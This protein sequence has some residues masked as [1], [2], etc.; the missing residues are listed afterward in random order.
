MLVLTLLWILSVTTPGNCSKC[1]N[2]LNEPS[3]LNNF[4]IELDYLL[5]GIVTI[6]GVLNLEHAPE[7]GVPHK[8]LLKFIGEDDPNDAPI[9]EIETQV[10]RRHQ[11]MYVR[12][13]LNVIDTGSNRIVKY[14]ENI[15]DLESICLEIDN[16]HKISNSNDGLVN[17]QL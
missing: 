8:D 7:S 12:G 14:P 11:C 16:N 6:E 5:N 4:D 9:L 3:G 1:W 10:N 2:I 15:R 13:T 17:F